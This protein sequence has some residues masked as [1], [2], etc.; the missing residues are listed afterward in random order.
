MDSCIDRGADRYLRQS[1]ILPEELLRK[2][3]VTIVGVGAIGRQVALQL[4][5]MGV[6]PLTLIDHD[7]VETVNL[8]AQGFLEADLG[9]LKVEAT[10]R[11]IGQLNSG[12]EVITHGRRY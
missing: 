3:P 9:T 4:G 1:T 2:H 11:L 8:G 12:V 6:S 10:A 7:G 5:V